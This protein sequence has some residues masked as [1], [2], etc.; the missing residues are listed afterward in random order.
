MSLD[1]ALPLEG[2]RIALVEDDPIMGE[3]LRQRLA[4][5]GAEV[6]WFD[7]GAAALSALP[8]CRPEAVVCDIRLPD[9]GGE[10]VFR[11]A[12][13]R[14]ATPFLF[15]TA[16]SDVDQAVRLMRLGAGDYLTKPFAMDDFLARLAALL[17]PRTP[18]GAGR[19]GPSPRMRK[20]ETLLARL[21]ER[22]TTLLLTGETGTGK[23]V[24]A[25][26]LHALG[27]RKA[28]F[29]AVNCA[30]IPADLVESALFGHERGAFTGAH[31]RHAGHAERAAAGI[32]FLDE[33]GE[34]P[35]PTQA[36]L[37][38]LLEDR[39]FTRV[40]GTEELPFRARIV[41]A[42][43]ADLGLAVRE[44]R[45]RQDLL[46]RINVVEIRVPPLRERP[47]DVPWLLQRFLAE[48]GGDDARPLAG[49][50][51]DVAYQHDWPGNV[52]ELRNR[53][54]RAAAL[55]GAVPIMPTD[56]F[57]EYAAAL[58]GAGEIALLA[59]ARDLAERV[60]I[61]RALARTDGNVPEA[62]RILGISRSTLFDKLR[63][64]GRA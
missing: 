10:A 63:R 13:A 36:K 62:A 47:E 57:P 3:S 7:T 46:Y 22:P 5:E 17:G 1:L 64:L 16:F 60:Q 53:V 26:H 23:E 35:L 18:A 41:A 43:N 31:A 27:P 39:R 34:L 11:E 29:V 4:I 12:V 15:V 30:A 50:T 56:L 40:G 58:G 59:S 54:E 48:F 25:R 52:R 42:T 33:I 19:L 21:A 38:R 32:L 8:A 37:L 51:E 55:A 20:I 49:A 2:R 24:C 61:E 28:P 9:L 44:G 45:F 6:R 14:H